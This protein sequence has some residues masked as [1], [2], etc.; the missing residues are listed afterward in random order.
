MRSEPTSGPTV[1]DSVARPRVFVQSEC[2]ST[3]YASNPSSTMTSTLRGLSPNRLPIWLHLAR[4]DLSVILLWASE[5]GRGVRFTRRRRVCKVTR[6]P[7]LPLGSLR[8][9]ITHTRPFPLSLTLAS[10]RC[11]CRLTTSYNKSPAYSR[12]KRYLAYGLVRSHA[13]YLRSSNV[14][15]RGSIGRPAVST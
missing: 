10:H 6:V 2:C 4:N 9:T 1:H 7:A 14:T 12:A 15:A 3:Q 5:R 8:S 13:A 11:A